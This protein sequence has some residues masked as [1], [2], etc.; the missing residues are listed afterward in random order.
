MIVVGSGIGGGVVADQLADMGHRVLVL[1]AG[2][3]LFPT[4]AGNLPRRQHAR[5]T[6][7]KHIW[8]LWEDFRAIPY[9]KLPGDEYGGGY[10]YN[11]GGRSV[12]WGAFIPR[13]TS[14]GSWTS[15]GA[16]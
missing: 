4:H 16:A 15:G 3:Y 11:L 8:E 7:V 9:D 10:A 6:V 13:M 14:R 2:G 12:F 1:E 5:D